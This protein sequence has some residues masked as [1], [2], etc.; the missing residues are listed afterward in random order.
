MSTNL[1]IALSQQLQTT[2]S[3]TS[4]GQIGIWA[5]YFTDTGVPVA[6]PLQVGSTPTPTTQIALPNPYDGGKVYLLIQSYD[7]SNTDSPAELTFGTNGVIQ[8]ESD[9]SWN[10]SE[11][12]QFRY[13]SFEL[14]LLGAAADAGN[15][16][17]VNVFGIPMSVD[18]AY[19][20][21]AVTQ[22]RGYQVNGST[23]FSDI[24]TAFT[25]DGGLV[26][27]FEY[28][29]LA[30]QPRLA[31]APTTALA[32]GGPG[33]VSASDWNAYIESIGNEMASSVRIAGQYNGAGTVD[34]VIG[35]PSS[36]SYSEWHNAGFYSYTLKYE[37]QAATVYDASTTLGANSFSVVLNSSA[38]TVTDPNAGQYVPNQTYVTFENVAPFAG[39]SAAELNSTYLVTNVIDANT[40]QFVIQATQANE[41]TTG[42]G[43]GI[44]SSV[45]L[46]D[47][48]FS[49]NAGDMFFTV[50]DPTASKY[51]AEGV[52]VTFTGAEAFAGFTADYLNGTTFTITKVLSATQYE[53]GISTAAQQGTGGGDTVA[54]TYVRPDAGTYIFTPDT[55]SQVKGTIKID[56]QDLANSIYSTLGVAQIYSPDGKAYEFSTLVNNVGAATTDLNTGFNTQW[57]AFFVKLLTGYIGGYMGGTGDIPNHWGGGPPTVDLSQNWNFDPSYAFGA[58]TMTPWTWDVAK[59][60]AGVPY[61]RYAE[62]FFAHTNSYGNGYS[63]ALMSLFQQG[64]PLIS[65]GYSVTLGTNPFTT[66]VGSDIVTVS[67]P[68]AG[69][70]GYQV[71]DLVTFAGA[72]SVG[73]I[74]MAAP[75]SLNIPGDTGKAAFVI[76]SVSGDSY[77]IKA[78]T[79]ATASAT[80]GGPGVVAGLDVASITLTLY[81]D[82]ETAPSGTTLADHQLYTPTEIYNTSSGPFVKALGSTD[83]VDVQFALGLGQMRPS[84]DLKVSLGFFVESHAGEHRLEYID[85]NTSKETLYQQ[86]SYDA[87]TKSLI[88][89]GGAA[90]TGT[91][92]TIND[93]PYATGINW[94]Q[95]VF[96]E[97][98][99]HNP[100]SR[101]Y[102][103]YMNGLAGS[104]ILNPNYV[105]P[106]VNQAGSIAIDGLASYVGSD[107][108]DQ[109][110][111]GTGG[112]S[113]NMFNGNS[114]SMDPRL[115][116]LITDLTIIQNNP[117]VW[118]APVAPVLGTL[119]NTVFS[120]WG[121]ST[122][123]GTPNADLTDVTGGSLAFGWYASDQS[124]LNYN[125]ENGQGGV[126]ANLTNK[127][128]ALNTAQIS[129]LTGAGLTAH[130]PITAVADIDGKWTTAAATFSNGSYSAVLTE[131]LGN[132]TA[133]QVGN[134]STAL[135]FTVELDSLDFQS[136]T[137][138]Y[139]ALDG[140]SG[141][142]AGN[143]ITLQTANSSLPNGTLLVYAT[144]ANGD[145]I[146]RDGQVGASLED[147]VLARIGSVAF[148]NG[149][150]MGQGTQSVYLPVGLQLHFAIQTGN[151]TIE[152]LPG[153]VV[154]GSSSLAVNVSGSFGTL[155]LSAAVDNMLSAAAQ[156]AQSQQQ[157]DQAWVYLTQG[158]TVEVD[159]AGSAYNLNTIHFVKIDVNSTTGA[160]S[161]G[162]VAYG[163]TDAFR[164]AVQQNWDPNFAVTGGRGNFTASDDWVVSQ[165][166]GYYAPVLATES[167]N[168]FV[169]G[170]A[171]ADGQDH[172]RTYGQNMFGFEDLLASQGSDFDYNDLVMKIAIA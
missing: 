81:D 103:I 131:F 56:T 115:L 5:V 73:G 72:G 107:V 58:S 156:L 79:S 45:P 75:P 143:W 144:D 52:E 12:Y 2:L 84:T 37:K 167:G 7:T 8:Q 138:S 77:T 22:T 49:A 142:A 17:D 140:T 4:N 27:N 74:N 111:T 105:A 114:L 147:S 169:I 108:S 118:Q 6:T 71:G 164:T 21:G 116:E 66:T 113:F 13:D 70:Y 24:E 1:T 148:D 25:A 47:N 67:D 117:V 69:T 62:I 88:A 82:G 126:I 93:L 3:S 155:N 20:N 26:H 166:T 31:A 125:V 99:E 154:T 151:N 95:L 91:G 161:V 92:L 80:G 171:N 168:I 65:T 85:F 30:G 141:A 109:Y 39:F 86:W 94:Y 128:G 18:I 150:V 28:G 157:D 119:S 44:V 15:L 133:V 120:N 130:A 102:N 145:L 89:A 59:Y 132:G 104:G 134:Q 101:T 98:T 55:N 63:D 97:K 96:S 23:V 172:I 48:P 10:N 152:Q 87:A 34:Y 162:G 121:G 14:S 64:G 153:V 46:G 137:G 149:T 146:G 124:W 41:T 33:G 123:P 53:V 165:G 129:F 19:T 16:T 68:K 90:P 83:T 50:T 54:P 106:G 61:D 122:T 112:L 35:Q 11:T 136:A 100:I 40:Y 127:I 42:G 36:V 158:S 43:S 78:A 159:V 163:S 51:A 32:P 110:L 170:T 60:G 38:I 76:Q 9:I 139:I 160:W 57:G 29:P 135:N